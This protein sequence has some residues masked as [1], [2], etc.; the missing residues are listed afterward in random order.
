VYLDNLIRHILH[1]NFVALLSYSSFQ[2][3]V[4]VLNLPSV[5]P[6]LEKRYTDFIVELLLRE[7]PQVAEST[8][9]HCHINSVLEETHSCAAE[10]ATVDTDFT[11]DAYSQLEEVQNLLGVSLESV[12]IGGTR[13][14]AIPS[15]IPDEAVDLPIQEKLEIVSVRVVDHILV[16]HGV[17]VAQDECVII[18]IV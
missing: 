6:I 2:E 15:V 5:C 3:V 4:S 8:V 14:A 9:D 1:D 18:E 16:G 13:R 17:W 11:L 7:G 10:R 12:G